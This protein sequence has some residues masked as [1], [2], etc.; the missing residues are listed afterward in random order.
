[1]LQRIHAPGTGQL[2]GVLARFSE[3]DLDAVRFPHPEVLQVL[4]TRILLDEAAQIT[5]LH[6]G[7]WLIGET[8]AAGRSFG[9]ALWFG[10]PDNVGRVMATASERLGITIHVV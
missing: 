8:L 3:E 4:D 6:G 7:G 9:H 2:S 1:L 10:R 5:A